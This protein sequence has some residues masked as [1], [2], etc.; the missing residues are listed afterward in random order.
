MA[1]FWGAIGLFK[2]PPSHRQ[3]EFENPTEA[4]EVILLADLLLRVLDRTSAK[5][6]QDKLPLSET[7]ASDEFAYTEEEVGQKP[8]AP[9]RFVHGSA[10]RQQDESG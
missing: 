4:A 5:I 6:E 9:Q 8:R 2:N 7:S 10:S 1:L 3:I